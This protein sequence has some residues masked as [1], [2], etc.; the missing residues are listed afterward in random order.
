MKIRFEF[1]LILAKAIA[2]SL[3]MGFFGYYNFGRWF[4]CGSRWSLLACY[5]SLSIGLNMSLFLRRVT[6]GLA[7]RFRDYAYRKLCDTA[8]NTGSAPLSQT[9]LTFMGECARLLSR[10]FE[11][12]TKAPSTILSW[13]GLLC[14]LLCVC[15]FVVGVPITLEKNVIF[16]AFPGLIYYLIVFLAYCDIIVQMDGICVDLKLDA[17]DAV[18]KDAVL[19][20]IVQLGSRFACGNVSGAQ[21]NATNAKGSANGKEI[22]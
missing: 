7:E 14:S 12:V 16:F 11:R 22:Q 3:M 9:T 8:I 10:R 2:I 21:F 15:T 4:S 1:A 17:G 13:I 19:P 5:L 18:A 6:E 20:E